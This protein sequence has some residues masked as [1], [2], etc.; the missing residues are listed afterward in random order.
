VKGPFTAYLL[1]LLTG[2]LVIY[3]ELATQYFY[4]QR[5][6]LGNFLASFY[7]VLHAL[8]SALLF[9]IIISVNDLDLV[10]KFIVDEPHLKAFAAG[11]EWQAFLRLRIFTFRMPDGKEL[12]IGVEFFWGRIAKL[13]ERR[14]EEKEE[15]GLFEFLRLYK[16][17]YRDLKQAKD[18]ALKYLDLL[19]LDMGEKATMR[20]KFEEARTPEEVMYTFVRFRGLKVFAQRFPLA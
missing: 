19:N 6:A 15:I 13:F 16:Q 14:I 5:F 18:I 9:H 7:F 2:G 10:A 11:L 3:V 8:L 20:K 17:K 12:P 1:A 4:T